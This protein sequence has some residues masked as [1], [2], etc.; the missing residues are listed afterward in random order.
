MNLLEQLK[1]RCDIISA[2]IEQLGAKT[3][4]HVVIDGIIDIEKY[5]N[6]KHR[7]L[8][9]LK[10]ANSEGVSWSYLDKFKDKEWLYKCGKSI[11]TIKRVIYT[12]YGILNDCQ[13]CEIPDADVETAFYHLQGIALINIKKVPGG[14]VS[15]YGEIQKAY[16][17]NQEL[18]RQQINTYNPTIII[19]G[20]TL[21]FFCE[22]DFDGL[23]TANKQTTEYGNEFYDTGEKLYIHTWHPAARGHGFDDEGYVMDIVNIVKKWNK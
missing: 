15:E 17:E 11:P 5:L 1:E 12:T 23:E 19:F 7:I 6:A 4:S 16:N 21:Q 13:W 2:Q 10:E 8:W 18:L 14:S 22:S 3:N 9:V 20:N